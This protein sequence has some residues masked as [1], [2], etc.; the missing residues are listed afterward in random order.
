M[1]RTDLRYLV[2]GRMGWGFL[3]KPD[4]KGEVVVETEKG[5]IGVAR[6]GGRLEFLFE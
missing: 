5:A 3:G 2:T 6:F 4:M 1:V